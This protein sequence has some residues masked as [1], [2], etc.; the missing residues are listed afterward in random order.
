MRYIVTSA[1]STVFRGVFQ[2]AYYYVMTYI[3]CKEQLGWTKCAWFA[4]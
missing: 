4:K 1:S 2:Y 3:T